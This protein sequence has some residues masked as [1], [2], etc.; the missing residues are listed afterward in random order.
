MGEDASEEGTAGALNVDSQRTAELPNSAGWTVK[1]FILG[2]FY[3]AMDGRVA[4]AASFR[5]VADAG[6]VTPT[7]DPK[8]GSR[9]GH[10][11]DAGLVT[12][13]LDPKSG[14]RMGHPSLWGLIGKT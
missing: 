8:S 5:A 4:R 13:T 1:C 9:M 14:S 3:F 12:P 2:E 11:P 6:L 7:L 10:P